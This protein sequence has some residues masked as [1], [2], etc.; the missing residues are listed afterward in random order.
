MILNGSAH[1]IQGAELYFKFTE[2][3]K[4]CNSVSFSDMV[5][6]GSKGDSDRFWINSEGDQYVKKTLSDY[7]HRRRTMNPEQ[8]K[9]FESMT[10]EQ[11]LRAAMNLYYSA[12]KLKAAALK[13]QRPDWN[14]E[15]IE[16]KVREIFLYART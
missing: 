16:Q 10:P 6:L 8:K 11:K 1:V 13:Q 7:L 3:N 12:R 9:I 14:E 4:L 2:K 15:Q 5:R